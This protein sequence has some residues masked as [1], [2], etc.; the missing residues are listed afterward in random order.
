MRWGLQQSIVST[1]ANWDLHP[2]SHY[3]DYPAL[4]RL[5]AA[6]YGYRTDDIDHADP[7]P[8]PQARPNRAGSRT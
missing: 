7:F 2:R 4:E 1:I 6:R 8:S 5:L 3:A